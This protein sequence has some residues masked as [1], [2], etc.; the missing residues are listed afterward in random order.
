[1]HV[2]KYK[3]AIEADKLGYYRRDLK[4]EIK[5]QKRI[6][7][8]LGCKFVRIDPSRENFDIVDEFSRIKD[9]LLKS[10]NKATKKKTKKKETNKKKETIDKT[11]DRLLNLEFKSNNSMKTKLL[12]WAVK[13]ILP[14]I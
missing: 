6:K 1:M 11:S 12:R 9:Y 5:R 13:K 4:S 10:T 7:E 3:L 14:N 8:K 2:P